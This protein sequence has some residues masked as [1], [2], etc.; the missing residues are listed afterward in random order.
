MRTTVAEIEIDPHRCAR[1]G[2]EH[3]GGSEYRRAGWGSHGTDLVRSLAL[4]MPSRF[5]SVAS[6]QS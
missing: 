2:E 4:V 5:G 3:V 6:Q 1:T